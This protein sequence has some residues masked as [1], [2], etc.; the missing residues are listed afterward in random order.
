MALAVE[1]V[2]VGLGHGAN[3]IRRV[4][5][6]THQVITAK[7]LRR[8]VERRIRLG[9]RPGLFERLDGAWTAEPGV[10]VVKA[11]V[12]YG[13]GDA[14]T[15]VVPRGPCFKGA[16]VDVSALVLDGLRHEPGDLHDV[17]AGSEGLDRLSITLDCDAGKSVGGGVQLRS[18]R[19]GCHLGGLRLNAGPDLQNAVPP[20]NR[21]GE[22]VAA[23]FRGLCLFEGSLAGELDVCRRRTRFFSEFAADL[24]IESRL[25]RDPFSCRAAG[26]RCFHC[27][28]RCPHAGGKDEAGQRSQHSLSRSPAV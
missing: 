16:R 12:Q 23:D 1:R 15:G 28:R 10:S 5:G 18:T 21:G 7:E 27:R 3:R 13:Y 25:Q 19:L 26:I 22:S 6:V 4:V 2:E 9:I 20:G 17:R 24:G 14:L 11:R 8:I